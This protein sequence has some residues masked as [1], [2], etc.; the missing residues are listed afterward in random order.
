MELKEYI[1]KT[2]TDI[3]EGTMQASEEM[4]GK[5]AICYNT[6]VEYKNYPCMAYSTEAKEICAPLTTVDF[7]V[8][9]EIIERSKGDVGFELGVLNVVSGKAGKGS[10]TETT[11]G[12]E[13]SFSIPLVWMQ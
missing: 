9:V 5:V 8:R 10:S 12:N 11:A 3:V 1:K 13:I 6:D 2:L 7:K 4:K